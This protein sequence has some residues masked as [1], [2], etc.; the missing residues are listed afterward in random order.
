MRRVNQ[1]AASGRFL[2]QPDSPMRGGTLTYLGPEGVRIELAGASAEELPAELRDPRFEAAAGHFGLW[3]LRQSGGLPDQSCRARGVSVIEP[4]PAVLAPLVA[5]FALRTRERRVARLL[6]AL[7]RLPFGP[8]L[9][10][11]WHA[12]RG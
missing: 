5:P 12:R 3:R 2:R 7:L 8:R 10:R 6:F 9:L 4:R 1:L 11:A